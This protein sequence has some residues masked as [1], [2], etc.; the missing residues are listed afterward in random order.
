MQLSCGNRPAELSQAERRKKLEERRAREK[1]IKSATCALVRVARRGYTKIDVHDFL[2]QLFSHQSTTVPRGYL[3]AP[4]SHKGT[5][6]LSKQHKCVFYAQTHNVSYMNRLRCRRK[7]STHSNHHFQVPMT[8]LP[9]TYDAQRDIDY[10]MGRKSR[11]H[12]QAASGYAPL[13]SKAN[14]WT[15]ESKTSVEHKALQFLTPPDRSPRAELLEKLQSRGHYKPSDPTARLRFNEPRHMPNLH[16]RVP[17][18]FV[19]VCCEK[20]TTCFE[21]YRKANESRITHNTKPKKYTVW[22]Y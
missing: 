9:L 13:F 11:R 22:V 6:F 8:P 16:R 1:A 15:P 2:E 18:N 3:I 5:A 7:A 12:R 17:A 10:V 20:L 4:P 14:T 21:E 19:P